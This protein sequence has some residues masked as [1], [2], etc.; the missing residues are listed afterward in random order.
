M[1][2]EQKIIKY[3]INSF[4]FSE[5]IKKFLNVKSL[6]LLHEKYNLSNDIKEIGSDTKTDAHEIFYRNLNSN[7]L[8]INN[9]Y[10]KFIEEI[11]FK[12]FDDKILFQKKPGFRIQHPNN[13]AVST[14]HADGDDVNKHPK[15]EIN[16]F[17]PLNLDK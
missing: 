8:N 3:D 6:E 9:L 4:P 7:N 14:W 17:L 12:E 1:H 11:L 2:F 15:G 16:I 5:I 13:V 10:Y